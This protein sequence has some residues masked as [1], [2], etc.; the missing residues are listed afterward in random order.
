MYQVNRWWAGGG[1]AYSIP[2]AAGN[3]IVRLHFANLFAGRSRAYR[4]SAV[5]SQTHA[6]WSSN[7]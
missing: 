5:L 3:Y 1:L 4:T 7:P 6:G 2:V